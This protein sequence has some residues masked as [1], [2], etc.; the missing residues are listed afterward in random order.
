MGT[1]ASTPN[2]E[3]IIIIWLV[4]GRRSAMVVKRTDPLILPFSDEWAGNL[5]GRRCSRLDGK[6]GVDV[7]GVHCNIL[8]AWYDLS[9][10]ACQYLGCHAHH[11]NFFVP[12]RT[13][14]RLVQGVCSM[15]EEIRSIQLLSFRPHGLSGGPGLASA[16]V[17][18][19]GNGFP[20]TMSQTWN[21]SECTWHSSS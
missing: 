18:S 16:F 8:D 6:G 2:N 5:D 11:P 9:G 1:T 20:F 3:I 14:L 19:Q 13:G 4:G 21:S 17:S 10:P 12:F 7:G 15:Q